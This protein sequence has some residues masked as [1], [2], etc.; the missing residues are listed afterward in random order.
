MR[1]APFP[2]ND[3][4]V[5][6]IAE[7]DDATSIQRLYA[8]LVSDPG[9]VNVE[10]EQLLVIADDAN[11]LLLVAECEG[12]VVATALLT[13][14]LDSMFGRQPF[15]V[16]ENVVVEAT[17][18]KLGCGRALF[19]AIDQVALDADCSKIMLLSGQ[20]RSAA[21]K[22]FVSIGYLQEEKCGFVK[23]RRHI[24]PA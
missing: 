12:N 2:A 24:S 10:P 15:A 13:L 16:V 11:S 22:F 9:R 21:H 19:E 7:P 5:I 20:S 6:R 3:N 18:R 23:Y 1:I 8:Q 4:L 17:Y 14:C